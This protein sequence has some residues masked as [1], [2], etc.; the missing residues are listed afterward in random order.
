ML[1]ADEGGAALVVAAGTR[2]TLLEF[3]DEGAAMASAVL[4]RL[5][6][7]GKVAT[8]AVTNAGRSYLGQVADWWTDIVS[9]LRG[10]FA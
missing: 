5:R 4:T 2:A 9:W 7:G 1:L 3:L 6:L 8:L 10:L